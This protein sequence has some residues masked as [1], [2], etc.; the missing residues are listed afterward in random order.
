MA[1]EE[2]TLNQEFTAEELSQQAQ[3]NAN[4]LAFLALAYL[5]EKGQSAAE[6]ADFFGRRVAPGWEGLHGQ[7]A[8][9]AARVI[10]L[11][12]ASVGATV[13]R[14]SGDE[15]QAEVTV[16]GWPAQD[17]LE[18]TGLTKADATPMWDVFRPIA[19]YLNLRYEWQE[20]GEQVRLRL[21]Q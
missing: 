3:G 10:A 7:G 2:N 8:H 11:N 20:E 15:Q 6:W 5:K 16:S 14:L 13:H 12:V 1:A 19:A 21:S 4:A 18:F 17:M 9:A